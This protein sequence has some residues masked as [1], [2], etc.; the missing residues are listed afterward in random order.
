MTNGTQGSGPSGPKRPHA[1]IE[2]K[3]T[4]IKPE[5]PKPAAGAAPAN[6]STD[7][8]ATAE[9]RRKVTGVCVRRALE[10]AAAHAAGKP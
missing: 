3:A 6:P 2:G 7:Q 9:Y 10:Q 4:E 1:T 5:A 8:R